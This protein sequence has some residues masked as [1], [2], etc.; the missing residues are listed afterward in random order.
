MNHGP[1]I[2]DPDGNEDLFAALEADLDNDSQGGDVADL[3]NVRA[4]R[5][6][7]LPHQPKPTDPPSDGG[8]QVE[9]VPTD[10]DHDDEDGPSVYVDDPALSLSKVPV[11]RRREPLLPK[12]AS[13]AAQ[14]KAAARWAAGQAAYVTA[15][16]AIRLPWYGAKLALRAPRGLA[17]TVG[18]ASRWVS[19][20][21]GAPMRGVAVRREDAELYL[22]LTRQ[23]DAKVR[24]RGLIAAVAG[25][26]GA[27]A[28]S[29][30]WVMS[31][32]WTHLALL[33]AAVAAFGKLGAPADE[34]L[35]SRSVVKNKTPV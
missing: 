6:G 9:L 10:D 23:R 2:P 5:P 19:D 29:V 1:N 31:P 17:R 34:P 7:Y 26:I 20:A 25:A 30:L 13:N 22:K 27:V 11:E 24:L 21:Q 4:L 15:F 14:F 8:E 3:A 16:H 32:G 12:W 35:I 28:L 18:R 33:A